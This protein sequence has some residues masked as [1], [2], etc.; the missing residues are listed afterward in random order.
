[1]T[2]ELEFLIPFYGEPRYLHEAIAGIR[3]LV[4]TDWRL[5]IVE[6]A[7]PEGAEVERQV[8]ALGDDRI[9]YLRNE[10]NI[11]VNANVHRCI[12]LAER[13]HFVITGYDD[14]VLPNYGQVVAG[15]LARH[16]DAALVQPAVEVVDE[17]GRRHNPLP[18]RVKALARPGHAGRSGGTEVVLRG[19]P[20]V[21]G[22][23]RGNWLYTPALC[24]RRDAL[25]RAPFRPGIDAAHDLAFVVD[26]L[27]DGGSLVVGTEVCFAY[28]RH[29]RSH[30]SSFARSGVRFE[31]ERRYFDDI[32][33]ELRRRGWPTAER[34]A[35][36]R[37]LSRFNAATQLPQ[38]LRA[39]RPATIRTLVRQ[40]LR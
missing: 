32:G 14:K 40:A 5:T 27:L 37:L 38:A 29:R 36:R 31:Q 1:V 22:L 23:L 33:A 10:R 9:R 26:V 20:A 34:A 25:Q 8:A 3:A 7:Y 28:R 11:G 39:A 16:P 6:D 13:D 21:A 24:Y 4:D 18:D 35:R 17:E 19:E 30:S 2:V 15:L 12:Q